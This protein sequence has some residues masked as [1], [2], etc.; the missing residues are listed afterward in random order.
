M[1]NGLGYGNNDLAVF[2]LTTPIVGIDPV[3]L[4]D[5]TLTNGMTLSMVGAGT[6]GTNAT[7]ELPWD[8][9]MRAGTNALSGRGG[10]EAAYSIYDSHFI[11]ARFDGPFTNPTSLE[12]ITSRGDSGG[13]WVLDGRLVAVNSFNAGPQMPGLYVGS[14]SAAVDLS[15]YRPWLETTL[16]NL[17]TVPEPSSLVLG[18]SGALVMLTITVRRRRPGIEKGTP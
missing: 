13:A 16:T 9:Y 3:Q 17:F 7:G 4:Y 11:C 5:G 12:W 14:S 1:P 10:Q 8:G 2:K 6:P 15:F 18:G